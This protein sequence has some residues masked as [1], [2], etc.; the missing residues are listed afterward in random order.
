MLKYSDYLTKNSSAY[1]Y[2]YPIEMRATLPCKLKHSFYKKNLVLTTGPLPLKW[3]FYYQRFGNAGKAC[4][5]CGISRPTLRKWFRRY[6][7]Y[8]IEGLKDKSR[9]PLNSLAQKI[10]PS[11]ETLV[12]KL[13]EKRR[14]GVKRIRSELYRLHNISL[15]LATIHKV[16]K[17]NQV[18]ALAKYRRKPR[19]V[20]RYNCLIPGERVQIDVC[21]IAP[22][23][24]QYTAIDDCTRWKVVGLYRRVKA[25][26]SIKFLALSQSDGKMLNP[27]IGDSQFKKP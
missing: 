22:R 26:N 3:I 27:S 1:I 23:L 10:T 7:Q 21:K 14:L 12:L 5:K 9:R 18:K 8:G 6:Q 16:L 2:E 13:R 11:T 19:K 20:K 25:S 17:R 4:L 24:Y 15:S